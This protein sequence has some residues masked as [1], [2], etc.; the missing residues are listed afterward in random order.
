MYSSIQDIIVS[1]AVQQSSLHILGLGRF[2]QDDGVC[3]LALDVGV[4]VDDLD[5]HLQVVQQGHDL[6]L[7]CL[8]VDLLHLR[9]AEELNG[10]LILNEGL[11][12]D[13]VILQL[14]RGEEAHHQDEIVG[15][16]GVAEHGD[17]VVQR[18]QL[19]IV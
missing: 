14:P 3:L 7:V 19:D 15:N 12:K 2:G 9:L 1:G 18:L 5:A 13:S 11:V 8:L 10:D 16:G 4:Q 6:D 17:Y